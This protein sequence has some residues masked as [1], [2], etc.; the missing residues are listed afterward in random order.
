M[1]C[2]Y[3]HKPIH[4][5][6]TYCSYCGKRLDGKLERKAGHRSLL[7]SL[8]VT[9]A[10]IV[11]TLLIHARHIPYPRGMYVLYDAQGRTAASLSLRSDG[12]YV[13]DDG[14][15]YSSY[16]SEM[17]VPL[18]VF[19]HDFDVKKDGLTWDE[20]EEGKLSYEKDSTYVIHDFFGGLFEKTL[21]AKLFYSED[22]IFL[23]PS[24]D[25][26]KVMVMEKP[27]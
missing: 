20:Q 8:I 14:Q 6:E 17:D 5:G 9:G 27:Q 10:V 26:S 15:N 24:D 2:P 19:H 1:N 21:D 12:T 23:Y 3:C 16:E 18:V 25:D 11:L 7:K 4:P 22:Q 13:L